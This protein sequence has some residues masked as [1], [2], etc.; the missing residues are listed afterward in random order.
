MNIRSKLPK[1]EVTI[2]A[3]MSGLARKYNAINKEPKSINLEKGTLC[4]TYCQVP[5]IYKN[6]GGEG[7]T[8]FFTNAETV[9]S[10]CLI[11][12]TTI[13][14]KMFERTGEIDRIEVAIKK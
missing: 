14:K 2:F 3:V 7:V 12:N 10:E 6:T 1:S 13:S 8:I 4:F 5:I 9:T 11:L